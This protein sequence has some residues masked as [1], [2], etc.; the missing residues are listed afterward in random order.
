MQVEVNG[1]NNVGFLRN[2]DTST[3][4][5][6]TAITLDATK[7]GTQFNFGTTATGGALIRSDINEVKL[8]KNIVVGKTGT[9][10]SVMQ[11]GTSGTVN[12]EYREVQL[13]QHHQ[14]NSME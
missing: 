5:N 6:T 2:S 3:T 13:L 14:Q 11:A 9:K 8:A 1:S 10:N 12:I 7:L 4:L